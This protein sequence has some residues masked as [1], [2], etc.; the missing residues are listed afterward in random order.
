MEP[1]TKEVMSKNLITIKY[2][3]TL[4][5]AYRKLKKHAIRHLPVIDELGD[6][7]GIISDRDVQRGMQP[8]ARDYMSF[9][10]DSVDFD[11]AAKVVDY[12][13]I[14]IKTVDYNEPLQTIAQRMVD[15]KISSFLVTKNGPIVGIITHEDL[16]Q[17]L[18]K[19]L[20]PKR[21]V[22]LIKD[23]TQ[24]FYK[25]PVGEVAVNLTA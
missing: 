22:K 10:F 12:M 9:E 13:S 24:W 5:D 16:L 20:G 6:V 15:E 2:Y 19:L 23:L 18:V 25:T 4:E 8:E 1:R 14:P 7:L 11:P 3:Q 21:E 17:V